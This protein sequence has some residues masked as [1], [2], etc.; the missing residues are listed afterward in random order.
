MVLYAQLLITLINPPMTANTDSITTTVPPKTLWRVIVASSLGTLIEWYDFYIF[1]AL[2]TLIIG[3]QFFPKV[4]NPL[5]QTLEA[6]ATFAV[7]FVVRPFGALFFG[8]LG[9][10]VG[11][12][13][14]FLV[15]LLLMG[16]S[17]F[18]IAFVPNYDAIG[19]FAP[20][21]LLLLRLFQGLALGGEY[22]G[23]ATYVAE[24]TPDN[25]RGYYTGFVQITATLGLVLAIGVILACRQ[26]QTPEQFRLWGWRIP[27]LLSGVL[28]VVSYFIRK[29]MAESPLFA[30][31]KADGQVAKNPLRESFAK[32]ENLRLVLLILFGLTAGQG[33]VYYTAHFYA[34]VFLGTIL[35]V[36]F[37]QV[38]QIMIVAL[39]LASPFS[40]GFGA[41][42]DR[43]GRKWLMMAGLML[44]VVFA[45][46][47][48]QQIS[49]TVAAGKLPG[50]PALLTDASRNYLML[51]VFV[52]V[53][54][55]MMVYGPIAAFLVE[56]FPTHIR[57]TALS[58]PYHI[59]N[60]IFGGL[61][62]FI[63]TSLIASTGNPFSGL[64]YPVIVGGVSVVVGSLF[65]PERK[66]LG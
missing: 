24:H 30:Q 2:A 53:F 49:D 50:S 6:L 1:G 21:V 47:I 23:A 64:W 33:C 62:P 39:V 31:L 5:V 42:S 15:T 66:G 26:S 36:D 20:A 55:V 8:R 56:S 16:G 63:A 65:L 41:L 44:F 32:K 17:T 58:L 19:F 61:T 14:T 43:I 35:K 38:N 34:S 54:F 12:K 10:M 13:Y 51:L 48:Y 28:V 37:V 46:P 4:D 9:D 45:F 40:V 22:G 27:F 7:G 29:N 59:G 52:Q 3:P 57:Y 18:A 11:R 25:R 60:G